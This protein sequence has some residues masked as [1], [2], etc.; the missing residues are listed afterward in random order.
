VIKP[1]GFEASQGIISSQYLKD[2]SDPQWKNDAGMKAF[3]EFLTKY[4]PEGNRID[5]AVMYGYTVA[6]GI[7]H[8]LK[9][10]GD[11]L[12]R[13]NVMKQ[14]ASIKDLQL[15]GLLPGIKVNTSATD[16]AP[17]AQ[18]QLVRFKG[19]AWERFGEVL[20]SDATN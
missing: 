4:F 18:V 7:V 6:Q 11:D 10:C 20:S 12:T 9:Q 14:A 2:T 17:I 3:D 1:A 13:A 16:F 8:V 15:G 5:G 19:E